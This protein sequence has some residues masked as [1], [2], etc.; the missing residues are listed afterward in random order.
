M[1]LTIDV[2]NTNTVLG[3][4]RGDELV[5]NWRLT[6]ARE[7][8]VDEYG[9]LM[10][11]LFT[12]AHL[13]RD[14]IGGVIISSVVPPVNWTLAETAR[15][16]FGKKALFVEPGVKTGMPV[17]V[18]NPLEVGADRI[19]NAVAAFHQF[20]GPC[21]VVDFGTAITFDA[22]SAKGEYL[23]GVIAPGIG[24]ASEALFARAARLPRV[25][26][27]DPGKVIGTNTVT[28]IQAGLYYGAVDMV[29]GMIVRIKKELGENAK[30]IATGGQARLVARGSKQI[31]HTD[32][33]LTLAGLRLIW[34]KNQSA[35]S[36]GCATGG[37]RP[38]KTAS[39]KKAQR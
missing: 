22:I 31:Q 8:T 38:D 21:I 4:F 36:S 5:A 16:Y 9:V 10:R 2:G 23:G 7:Q 11:N 19:V 29:D 33:L 26:I 28:H 1:L 35:E 24:I 13:D 34:E 12:L 37:Q 3:V 18:D 14:A 27:K 39:A 30:V 25:E 32:E 17:L 15:I 20:G 6:T